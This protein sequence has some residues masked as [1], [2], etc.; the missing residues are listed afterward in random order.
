MNERPEHKTQTTDLYITP[1][2]RK[3]VPCRNSTTGEGGWALWRP[4]RTDTDTY[5]GRGLQSGTDRP[6]SRWSRELGRP[7]RSREPRGGHGGAGSSGGMWGPLP[8]PRPSPH[9]SLFGRSPTTPPQNFL[10]EA[11]GY[12]EPS[13]AK[14]TQTV[15]KD[16]GHCLV[17]YG[18]GRLACQYGSGRLGIP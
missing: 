4:H 10:G 5:T 18:H 17:K 2:S 14:H 15:K 1:P 11:Q 3:A 9:L 8:R 13:G 7:W 16:R 6:R 12:Q